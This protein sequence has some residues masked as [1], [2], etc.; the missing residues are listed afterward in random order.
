M[1]N[2]YRNQNPENHSRKHSQ[3]HQKIK[4]PRTQI[5]LNEAVTASS[6]QL[7]SPNYL[8]HAKNTKS[9]KIFYAIFTDNNRGNRTLNFLE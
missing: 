1:E 8:K 6:N 5:N 3:R 7:Q 2:T 9:A 4:L